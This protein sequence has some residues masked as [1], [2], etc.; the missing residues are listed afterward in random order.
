MKKTG[1]RKIKNEYKQKLQLFQTTIEVREK[2]IVVSIILFYL[3]FVSLFL[4]P[5]H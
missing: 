3:F 1:K 2:I 5:P 4:Y